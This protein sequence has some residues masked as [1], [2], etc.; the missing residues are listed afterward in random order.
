MRENRDLQLL[1]CPGLLMDVAGAHNVHVFRAIGIQFL[2]QLG[3]EIIAAQ[4]NGP[5]CR[6]V[7]AIDHDNDV[8]VKEWST[9][10]A[11]EDFFEVHLYQLALMV[12]KQIRT[13]IIRAGMQGQVKDK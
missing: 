8:F 6:S 13:S 2:L 11:I 4:V 1:G 3:D 9:L 12:E 7:R 10:E 5:K